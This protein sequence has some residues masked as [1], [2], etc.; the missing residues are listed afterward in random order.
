VLTGSKVCRAEIDRHRQDLPF[1]ILRRTGT[2]TL[3]RALRFRPSCSG[4]SG[5]KFVHVAVCVGA[6][7][8]HVTVMT[9]NTMNDAVSLVIRNA[10]QTIA[11]AET[12]VSGAD[13]WNSQP[14]PCSGE[15]ILADGLR[16]CLIIFFVTLFGF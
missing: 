15:R 8:N 5:R 12:H 1:P 16:K 9:M 6:D 3:A 4:E 2:A 13:S 14:S 10:S 11:C 7:F